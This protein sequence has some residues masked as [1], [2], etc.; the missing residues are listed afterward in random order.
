LDTDFLLWSKLFDMSDC[1]HSKSTGNRL[2]SF[3]KWFVSIHEDGL[4]TV[5]MKSSAWKTAQTLGEVRFWFIGCDDF[6]KHS[7]QNKSNL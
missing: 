3:K 1:H 6:E 2:R 4:S 7:S 5:S